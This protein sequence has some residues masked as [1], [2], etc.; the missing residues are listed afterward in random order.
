[1]ILVIVKISQFIPKNMIYCEGI[2]V[3]IRATTRNDVNDC[4]GWLS[5]DNTTTY[6][7]GDR[8][9]YIEQLYE[10]VGVHVSTGYDLWIP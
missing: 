10:K 3:V 8:M 1:M 7:I 6:R 4:T 5:Y 9:I 2:K